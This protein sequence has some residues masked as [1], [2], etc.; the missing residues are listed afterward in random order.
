MFDELVIPPSENHVM[1]LKYMLTISL[2][3]FIPYIS[4]MLGATFISTYFNKKGK[5]EGNST[6]ARFAKDVIEKLTITQSAELAL[7]TIP[8]LSAFFA[9][10]QLLYT[11]KTIT[12]SILALSAVIFILS[13][14]F[15]YRYRSTFK[16]ESILATYKRFV[17]KDA[18]KPGDEHVQQIEDFEE[19]IVSTNTTSGTIGKYLLLLAS[20][21]FAGTTAL[22][23]SPDKWGEIGNV[24]QVIF[25]WQ[26]I[27]NYMAM[28]SLA[29]II[30]GGA[31]MFYFFSWNGGIKD[32]DDEY[33]ALVKK[34]SGNLALVSG[35]MF[36][37][38]LLISYVYLPS[39][40]QS[41]GVFY[42][43]V[44]VLI[45]S[46]IIGNFIYAMVKNSDTG[47]ATVVFVLIFVLIAFNI[48]KDQLVFG[49]AI[50]ENTLEITK[51]AE[52]NEKEAKQKMMQTSGVDA[53]QIFNQ[54][55]S[56]C[57]RF[58]VKLV[59]P[60]YQQTIPK[61][62]GDVKKLETFIFNPIKVDPNFPPMPN[63]GL[64]KK[65]AHAMAEWLISKVGKK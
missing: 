20:Y 13:F 62:N 1:L 15:I 44:I 21:L 32:M 27:F 34:V 42:Y 9:Y 30:T 11:A 60:P 61:Y 14:V 16:I 17:N 35:I 64:K 48:I 47:S 39:E 5:L 28:V 36:P 45:V 7:G 3:L 40:A 63:Q 65:E 51:V 18:M 49:N 4:M 59:G 43:M 55:C 52:E 41:P 22:A 26:T 8:L 25:S 19:G 12:I 23:S 37:L 29:G 38:M 54:K 24:L 33:A 53:Q 46:L 31:I 58:D 56:A 2:L 10:A 57:H 6:Y 50:H